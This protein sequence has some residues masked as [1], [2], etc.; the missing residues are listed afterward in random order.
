MGAVSELVSL[1]G[2]VLAEEFENLEV[3][4]LLQLGLVAAKFATGVWLTLLCRLLDEEVCSQVLKL[5]WH[6]ALPS[7]YHE[8]W[9]L[10]RRD[11][12]ANNGSSF[13]E[14]ST[15]LEA[16]RWSLPA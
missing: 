15:T 1:V 5:L 11:D 12:V 16:P 6:V 2:G 13:L 7:W 8:E 10:W 3:E 14:R 4:I 9:L